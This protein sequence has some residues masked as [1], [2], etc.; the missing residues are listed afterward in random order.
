MTIEDA[1]VAVEYLMSRQHVPILLGEAGVGKT[2]IIKRIAK[3]K[4]R[5]LIV[6]ILSQ[7]EPGDLL[8]LPAKDEKTGKTV[9][10]KPDWWPEDKEQTIIFL[11]E[12]NRAHVSVRNAVMQLLIDKR[13]HNNRLPQNTWVVAAMNPATEDYEVEQMI[14][15]AFIDRFVWLKV[16]NNIFDWSRFMAAS[17]RLPY[18]YIRV[19]EKI[20]KNSDVAINFSGDYTLPEIVPTPRNLERLGKIITQATDVIKPLLPEIS[21]GVCGQIG[22]KIVNMYE[23]FAETGLSA[24]ELFEGNIEAVKAANTA[25]RTQTLSAAI[26]YLLSK[27]NDTTNVIDIEQE[28][29]DNFATCLTHYKKEELGPLFRLVK[30]DYK[31]VI[32]SLKKQSRTFA[33][34][35]AKLIASTDLFTTVEKLR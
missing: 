34:L 3:E 29:I 16:T 9:Y 14:D 13:I 19:I 11:D 33:K 31:K 1:K 8:G 20:T 18:Q 5:K 35:Y 22:P 6:L 23:K 30:D 28:K 12:I 21:L 17:K 7:M 10:Y 26:N 15:K 27:Y 4:N 25:T 24:D 32:I 2:E